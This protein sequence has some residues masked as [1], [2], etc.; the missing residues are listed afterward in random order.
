MKARTGIDGLD[1]ILGGGLA[2]G[3]VCLLKGNPGPSRPLSGCVSCWTARR[4]ARQACKSPC[5]RPTGFV[6][7]TEKALRGAYLQPLVAWLAEQP[8]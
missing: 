6:V 1:D 7:A 2:P 8:P 4:A 3:H 5:P